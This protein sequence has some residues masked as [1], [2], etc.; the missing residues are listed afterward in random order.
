MNQPLAL[1]VSLLAAGSLAVGQAV[2]A[3]TP[4]PDA[5]RGVTRIAFFGDSLTDG[6][7]YEL[8]L[9]GGAPLVVWVNGVKVY[10]LPKT[11]GYHPNAV[12]TPVLLKAGSNEIIITTG[13]YAFVGVKL[14]E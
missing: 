2:A 13:F 6:S 5:L 11:N 10:A 9:G 8:Q 7:D 4:L 1:C 14:L 12:R 3:E